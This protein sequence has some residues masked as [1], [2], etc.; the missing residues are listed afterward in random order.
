MAALTRTFKQWWK[1]PA[2]LE[3]TPDWPWRVAFGGAAIFLILS[4]FLPLWNMT[5]HAPQYPGGLELTAYGTH[6]EG[7]LDEVNSL[8]HYIG[9]G[10]I[11]EEDLVEL[12]LFPFVLA[13]GVAALLAAALVLPRRS[14]TTAIRL[15]IWAFP[16]GFLADVQFWLYR[17]GNDLDPTA[18][19]AVEPFTPT[20]I[21]TTTVVNFESTAMVASGFWAMV[22]AAALT[23]FGPWV[24]RF[25]RDSWNNTGDV[26]AAS[27]AAIVFAGL[28]AVLVINQGTASAGD[29]RTTADIDEM[30]ANA[31]PGGTVTVPAGTYNGQLVIEKPVKLLA[32]GEV[33]I[34]AG[35][36]GHVVVIAAENV[37]L[38]GFTIQGSAR[39]VTREPS[40][41]RVTEDG[42]TIQDLVVRDALYGI[43]LTGSDRHIVRDNHISSVTEFP[44]ERRGH[45][46]Y[47]YHTV[48]NVVEGNTVETAKDGI[49]VGFGDRNQIDRNDVRDVRYGI[50][51][52][53]AN[54]NSF[55]GNT[56]RES[57]AGAALMYSEGLT[58]EDNEFSHNTS[59]ASGYGIL[60]KDVDGVHVTGNRIHHNRLGMTLE[61][62]PSSPAS[63]ALI[64][65]NLIGFNQ[66]AIEMF[67]TTRITFTGNS[68][69]GN[70]RQI[71]SRGGG[72][73]L[74]D[75]TWEADGRGNYWDTYTGYDTSGDGVGDRPYEY[76]GAYESLMDETPALRAYAFTLAHEAFD[77][78]ASRFASDQ[79]E[80]L[81]VDPAPL[82]RPTVRLETSESGTQ[83]AIL[84][85]LSALIVAGVGATMWRSAT[86]LQRGWH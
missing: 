32:D 66:T 45:A 51:Y 82:M 60:M 9:V 44:V 85:S 31:E 80:P 29:T 75:N 43:V 30:I 81:V 52:M 4:A 73:I 70:L 74:G 84:G 12:T 46:I 61:A 25:L 64:E 20:V 8:N 77:I 10:T 47:L 83:R 62:V 48:E 49:F 6:L 59:R 41:V 13:A 58:L 67:S 57:I 56:F 15:S 86:T 21:G 18:P 17:F 19:M 39:D 27:K 22:L 26:R 11:E 65:D 5:L 40:G 14:V 55:A 36:A 79:A 23:T 1:S 37:T 54:N 7:D 35:R 2:R 68:F 38:E 42:A 71:E 50:H 63:T 28:A 72:R 53:Y 78:A 3:A 16:I 33:I 69:T 76:R 34:D 24:I